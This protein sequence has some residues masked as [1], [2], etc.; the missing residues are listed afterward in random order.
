MPF[1]TE[2]L[3]HA[4]GFVAEEDSIMNAEWPTVMTSED[5]DRLGCSATVAELVDQK[6]DLVRAARNLKGTY[7]IPTVQKVPFFVKPTT[8]EMA[9]FL[10]AGANELRSLLGASE[11]TID[12]DY[13]PQIVAPS[14]VSGIGSVFMPLDGIV[15]VEEEK[16]K[17][18][19]QK[20]ELTK[21][22]NGTEG[23]L[24]NENFVARAP[25][26]VVQKEREKILDYKEK[27]ARIETLLASF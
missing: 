9:V 11:L 1:V 5:V 23:K 18:N 2:E 8:A 22:I 3:Y 7:N 26:A 6:F 20:A 4:I 27:L 19:K 12:T 13:E 16:A 21:A 25:E 24:K 10:E 15:D 14:G 17:L